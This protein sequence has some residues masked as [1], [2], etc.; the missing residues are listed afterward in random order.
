MGQPTNWQDSRTQSSDRRPQADGAFQLV[1]RYHVGETISRGVE[2][3]LPVEKAD[4]PS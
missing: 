2:L 4:G 3:L 1:T